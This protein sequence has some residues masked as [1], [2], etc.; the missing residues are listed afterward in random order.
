MNVFDKMLGDL[1]ELEHIIKVT[2][3]ATDQET[4]EVEEGYRV[5]NPIDHE[6]YTDLSG[7]GLEGPFRLASGKVVYYDPTKGKYYDRDTDL[8]LSN[9]EYFAHADYTPRDAFKDVMEQ[10][11][12][13]K[14]KHK[15]LAEA[16]VLRKVTMG[17][18]KTKIIVQSNNPDARKGGSETYTVH[19]KLGL[20]DNYGARW[21]PQNKYWYWDVTKATEQE[22]IKLA[23]ELVSKANDIIADGNEE[24]VIENLSEIKDYLEVIKAAKEEATTTKSSTALDLIDQYIDELGDDLSN[25][26]LLDDLAKY[27]QL[28]REFKTR[29]G[30][31]P[32]SNNNLFLIYIQVKDKSNVTEVGSKVYW[33]ERGYQP[34]DEDDGI[35]IIRVAKRSSMKQQVIQIIKKHPRSAAAFAKSAG[36]KLVNGTPQIPQNNYNGFLVWAK[37]NGLF[38]FSGGSFAG[39][40][41]YDNTQVMP[42]EGQEQAVPPKGLEW[43][44]ENSTDDEKSTKIIGALTDFIKEN[45]IKLEDVDDMKGAAGSSAGGHIRIRT[46]SKGATRLSTMVHELAHEMLH[47]PVNIAKFKLFQGKGLSTAEQE[48]QAESVAYIILKTYDFDITHSVNY[49]VQ[50][51]ADRDKIKKNYT[52]LRDAASIIQQAIDKRLGEDNG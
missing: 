31:Y 19:R 52:V 10:F 11:R 37:K 18:D 15:T 41:V 36:I 47:H 49:L 7:E 46:N 9:D 28:S 40:T 38:G 23:R 30:Q 21:D 16:I 45:G 48:L 35:Y 43:Y 25:P 26:K 6:R 8:Y 2:D 20:K 5:V 22:A 3:D 12:N 39:T 51:R 34:K 33:A 24:P 27:L 4:T 32:Y 42:I 50:W 44:D 1:E 29:H 13:F 17:D 14:K